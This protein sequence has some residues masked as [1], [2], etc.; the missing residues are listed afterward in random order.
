MGR[1]NKKRKYTSVLWA[2]FEPLI[3]IFGSIKDRVSFRDE[4]FLFVASTRHHS[5]KHQPSW[6]WDSVSP[7][8][9]SLN[10]SLLC[11]IR[12]YSGQSYDARLFRTAERYSKLKKSSFRISLQIQYRFY[13]SLSLGSN[14]NQ[15]I[16]AKSSHSILLTSIYL[17]LYLCLETKIIVF[18]S[19]FSLPQ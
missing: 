8:S 16:K 1:N 19:G 18:I 4:L 17:P 5:Y 2:G 6:P 15:L 12:N 7:I 9:S 13:K 3:H 14:A 10:G 11:N